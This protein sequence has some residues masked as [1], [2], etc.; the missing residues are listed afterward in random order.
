MSSPND[1]RTILLEEADTLATELL[2]ADVRRNEITSTMNVLF[3]SPGTW[4][5]RLRRGRM[6]AAKVPTLWLKIRGK[7]AP[8]RLK[9]VSEVLGRVLDEH[10]SEAEVRY[11]LGWTLRLMR[12][13]E[14]AANRRAG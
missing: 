13:R 14:G 6:L 8:E 1:R 5:Q 12:A 7:G 9:K 4:Q 10:P 3:Y 11:L 2:A